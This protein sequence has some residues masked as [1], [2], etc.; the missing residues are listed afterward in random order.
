MKLLEVVATKTQLQ[1]MLVDTAELSK[2]G[3]TR[4]FIR[5]R[6]LADHPSSVQQSIGPT[7]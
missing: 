6:G 5:A 1:K 3:D 2:L 4:D 7:V